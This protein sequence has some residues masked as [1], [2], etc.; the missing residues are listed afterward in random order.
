M[1]RQQLWLLMCS[2]LG[3]WSALRVRASP[4]R[5]LRGVPAAT[6]SSRAWG[7]VLCSEFL[8]PDPEPSPATV[9]C[10]ELWGCGWI[11]R[12]AAG[13]LSERGHE[14][15]RPGDTV[16]PELQAALGLRLS[17][18]HGA[19]LASLSPGTT[20]TSAE[21]QAREEGACP[22]LLGALREQRMERT[23]P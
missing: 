10:F 13:F 20:E 12:S 23:E 4:Q 2:V 7:C 11:I 16:G 5:V 3:P 18:V 15:Q 22:T 21:W 19:G 17:W 14:T 8:K 6:P 1:A 9:A